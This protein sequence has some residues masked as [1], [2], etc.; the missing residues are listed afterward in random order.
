MANEFK[1]KNGII[2]E[3]SIIVTGSIVTTGT[4]TISGSIASASYATN[5]EFLDNMD[6]TMFT[7]TSSFNTVSASLDE[8][9]KN[10]IAR[11]GSFATTGSNVFYGNQTVSASMFVSGSVTATGQIVA[12]TINVQSVTSSVVYSSGSNVFGNDVSN[13]QTFTGSMLIT[14]SVRTTGNICATGTGCF[15][16]VCSPTHVGGT[17]NGTTAC[18][19]T[20]ICSDKGY[21]TGISLGGTPISATT[22]ATQIRFTNSGGDLYVGQEGSVAGAFYPGASAYDNVIYTNCPVNI[23]TGGTSRM[24]LFNSG[25]TCFQNTVC[26]PTGIFSGCVGI[27]TTSPSDKLYVVGADNGITICSAAVSRPVLSLVNGSN[28]MLK[29]SANSTYGAIASCTGDLMYFYGNSIGIGQTAPSFGLEVY[30]NLG[31]AITS[32]NTFAANFNLIFNRDNTGGTRG[33]FNFL[34]DQNAGY[35]QTIDNYPIVFGTNNIERMRISNCGFVAIGVS[36][37]NWCCIGHGRAIEVGCQ[38]LGIWGRNFKEVHLINNYYYAPTT[39]RTYAYCACASDYEQ[40]DGTHAWYTAPWGSPGGAVTF[41]ERMR[42][43]NSGCVS[44]GTAC[45]R[46]TLTIKSINDEGIVITRPSDAMS[47]HLKISTTETG[48][49]AYTVKYNTFNNE[50][51]FNTYAGGGTGGNIIFRTTS[52]GGAGG[53]TERLRI[54]CVGQ[55]KFGSNAST[56][57]NADGGAGYIYS[58]SAGDPKIY[59][60]SNGVVAFLNPNG[61]GIGCTNPGSP[62]TIRCDSSSTASSLAV[63]TCFAGSYR[64]VSVNAGNGISYCIPAGTSQSPYIEVQGGTPGVGGGS[65]KIRTGAMGAV[66]DKLLVT[67]GGLILSCGRTSSILG[68]ISNIQEWVGEFGVINNNT[69]F[70]LFC[71]ANQYDNL[72]VD[73]FAY[74]NLGSFTTMA[75]R[76][77]IGYNLD[78]TYTSQIGN[79][80]FICGEESGTTYFETFCWKNCSGS[81]ISSARVALRIFGYGVGDNV[82]SGGNNLICTTCLTRI[83]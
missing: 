72:I 6:S 66:S 79:V 33:C 17:F 65:F 39:A 35:I 23:I 30:S 26:A 19:S 12:Q 51:I 62:L 8:G 76:F 44:I 36:P 31:T 14:G 41:T 83:K 58:Y 48:G 60:E 69:K 64:Y 40:F 81:N 55:V 37:S 22:S 34:A 61:V 20:A 57:I 70:N 13:T 28:L 47:S 52:T 16:V 7:F 42:I 32:N 80:T 3:G 9:L 1:V 59:L 77:G 67:Q 68:P 46:S 82:S 63:A 21:F 78:N 73:L 49:D 27:G 24:K 2:S 54:S 50:M 53:E 71:I 15:A 18:L 38:G 56:I 45:A 5:A 25:I 11:T 4:V 43:S 74:I 29:L 75:Y 10:V